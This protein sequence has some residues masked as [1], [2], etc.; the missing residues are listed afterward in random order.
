MAGPDQHDVTRLLAAVS[1]GDPRAGEQLIPIVYDELRRLAEH[2]MAAETPGQTLQATA[3]VHE[4]YLRLVGD[5]DVQWDSR[6]HFFA[7]AARAMRRIL[8]ERARR[9]ARI[10]HGGGRRRADLDALQLAGDEPAEDL[11]ALDDA[12]SKLALCD[13]RKADVVMLRYF[14]GLT[15][16]D[17]ARALGVS[18]ATVK[19]DW[20]FAKAWLYS[21]MSDDDTART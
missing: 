11:V 8:V 19:S 13:K 5:H 12:L 18:P 1:D 10:K 9:R 3:L 15:I 14:T 21:E 7:A 4:A 16:D 17:T 2:R 20:S 6:G